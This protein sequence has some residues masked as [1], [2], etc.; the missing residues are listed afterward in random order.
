MNKFK[1]LFEDKSVQSGQFD[2][3]Y[4]V[5]RGD[6]KKLAKNYGSKWDIDGDVWTMY[7]TD[8]HVMTYM[9]KKGELYTSFS[10][11][12][13]IDMIK[14]HQTVDKFRDLFEVK[15]V[16]TAEGNATLK[17]IKA[18]V[19]QKGH[20]RFTISNKYGEFYISFNKMPGGHV[21]NMINDFIKKGFIEAKGSL[22]TQD[23]ADGHFK[24]MTYQG[25]E[26]TGI[27]EMNTYFFLTKP[28][29]NV[30]IKFI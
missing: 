11:D 15:G 3:E 23:N 29:G 24:G 4:K 14:G 9:P 25:I 12:Q 30:I 27:Q 26:G 6:A 16:S 17:E 2:N 18:H 5:T 13:I 22:N 20:G 21:N 10:E 28:S 19:K 7:D 1:D 8:E